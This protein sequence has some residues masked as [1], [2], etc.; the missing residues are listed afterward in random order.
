MRT[1]LMN[2]LQE[3][4]D[5]ITQIR[6]HLHEHPE[7]SFHEAETAKFIQDFYKGKDVEVATEV[8]NGHA[9][10]VTIKGGK[11]GKTIALRADFDALPIEEQTDLPFKS[12]N[13][14][15]MHACGHDGHTAYLLV[16]ADCLIQLKE[17]IPGTIKIVHQ[18]AEETPPGGA[19]SVVESGILDDVDQIFGIHVFPFGESGQ[20]YY[21]SGYAMAGRTYFKLK[22]QGVGGHGSSPHMAN[23]AIVAGA[24]FVTSIQTVVSRRLNPFDTGVITIGSFDGKGSFNVI[25]DA[26]ELEGDVRYMN[27]ENRDKMDAEIHRIVAGI[28]AMFGVTVEL[29]YTN[30]YPP[31]YNDPAVTE[32]VVASLQKG[33]GEYLTG[34]SEYDM[35]SGSEDFAYYLQKIPGV[36]FYIGA[37]PKNTS[38]AY[39]NHHPKFDIDEDALLVA[40]K[41]VADV[42]LDY[43][44]LNG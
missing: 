28:E 15:V 1:K 42:V 11:P 34:I 36:F 20:V 35:L 26:V 13:P 32:Q 10:V 9:V 33:V 21:H 29:T 17:N 22:I 2:M 18:H 44:K 3:R 40:A 30:D 23:D 27:T 7:L 6:R 25:K 41:S 43:Y 39:F 14:G 8:G 38:N 16:L 37:K 12:K 5:E 31:L 4:K 24:Y 19:K